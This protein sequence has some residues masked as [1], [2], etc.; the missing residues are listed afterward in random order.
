M[1]QPL[2]I[3]GGPDLITE[4][5]CP[6]CKATDQTSAPRVPEGFGP[7]VGSAHFH[8]CPKTGMPNTP[9][10]KAGVKAK[11]VANLRPD[12]VGRELV[13]MSLHDK[14]QPVMSITVEREDGLDCVVFAPTALGRFRDIDARPGLPARGRAWRNRPLVAA[15][16]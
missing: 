7:V 13:Q 15:R 10:V 4:W 16:A 2:P 8:T 3:L 9:M 1:R 14:P 12:Y 11:I 6:A 5:H